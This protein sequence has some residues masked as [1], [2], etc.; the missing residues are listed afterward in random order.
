MITQK[1]NKPILI[2]PY[3]KNMKNKFRNINLN[4]ETI[5]N[6]ICVDPISDMVIDSSINLFYVLYTRNYGYVNKKL[7]SLYLNPIF[8]Y[9]RKFEVEV[10]S[11]EQQFPGVTEYYSNFIGFVI[12]GISIV[13]IFCAIAIISFILL[14]KK[15][16]Q[17]KNVSMK[18]SLVKLTDSEF[19]SNSNR[20]SEQQKINNN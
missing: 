7:N 8:T 4:E 5:D 15:A 16:E 1:T 10:N 6:Y 3:E 9:Q 12:L 17:N 13:V 2:L 20:E 11:Y 19:T 14:K 18:Q